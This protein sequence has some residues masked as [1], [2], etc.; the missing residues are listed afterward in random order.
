MNWPFYT[1]ERPFLSLEIFLNLIPV[2]WY[3]YSHFS[4]LLC[5][6]R[7][8]CWRRQWQPTPVLLP[9]K[10]HGWRSLVGCSPWGHEESDTYWVTSLSLFTFKHWRRKWQPTPVFL[11]GESQG[12]R[13]LVG[14]HLWGR[15]DSD[16]TKTMQQQQHIHNH[17]KLLIIY[18]VK[19]TDCQSG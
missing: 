18:Q 6:V 11:P 8:V 12:R 7:M 1:Y 19:D 16:T 14:C 15:T 3:K 9:G 4:F 13:S 5:T 2:L 17:F 10:S